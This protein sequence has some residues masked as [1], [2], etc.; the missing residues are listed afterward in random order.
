VSIGFSTI[1]PT[2]ANWETRA[3]WALIARDLLVAPE[4]LLDRGNA[5]KR[6]IDLLSEPEIS[7]EDLHHSADALRCAC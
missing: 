3:A 4:A 1:R 2:N 7:Y 5:L 6:F